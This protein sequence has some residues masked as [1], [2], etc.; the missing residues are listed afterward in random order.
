LK[1]KHN[2]KDIY[3][4]TPEDMYYNHIIFGAALVNS[5]LK[6]NNIEREMM[7]VIA[8]ATEAIKK[9]DVQKEL[10]KRGRTLSSQ[11]VARHLN[12][13]ADLG[14][15]EKGVGDD[16]KS[17]KYQIGQMFQEFLFEIDWKNVVEFTIK[18]MKEMYPDIADEYIKKYCTNVKLKHPF[19]NEII[20][21]EKVEV[22][23][24]KTTLGQCD[25][26]KIQDTK[27]ELTDQ[28]LFYESES[29]KAF[30]KFFNETKEEFV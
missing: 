8:C 4:I 30:S 17:Y 6:C 25:L 5:S 27:K 11:M 7:S 3:F 22:Q 20:E 26:T 28:E 19:T 24:L 14:Y 21:L 2:G 1:F 13:L 15:L 12:S 18:T 23:K 9:S 16:K 29:K 10:K